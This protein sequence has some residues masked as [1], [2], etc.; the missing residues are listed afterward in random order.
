MVK[1]PMPLTTLLVYYRS[2]SMTYIIQ[3]VSIPLAGM[4][5]FAK[6]GPTSLR[7]IYQISHLAMDEFKTKIPLLS[8]YINKLYHND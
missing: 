3:F 4:G 5:K 6:R 8:F 7:Q 1:V 2:Y